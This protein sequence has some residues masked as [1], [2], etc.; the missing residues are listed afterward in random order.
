ML[1]P[2]L[3]RDLVYVLYLVDVEYKHYRSVRQQWLSSEA[4]AGLPETRTV[5]IVNVPAT[6]MTVEG[7]SELASDCGTVQKVWLSR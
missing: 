6:F 4:R 7:I 2:I 5:V 1:T 3:R